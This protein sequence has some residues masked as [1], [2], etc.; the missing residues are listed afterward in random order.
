MLGAVYCSFSCALAHI[1]QHRF[2]SVVV[3]TQVVQR[4]G[5]VIH[6]NGIII[7]LADLIAHIQINLEPTTR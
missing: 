4:F 7:G 2:L 6:V 1:V 5:Q 3:E